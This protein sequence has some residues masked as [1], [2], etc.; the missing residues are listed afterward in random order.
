MGGTPCP[1]PRRTRGELPGATPGFRCRNLVSRAAKNFD[2]TPDYVAGTPNTPTSTPAGY[3]LWEY[4]LSPLHGRTLGT[5]FD[6]STAVTS[7]T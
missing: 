5:L 6:V 4:V 7:S 2:R 1:H 3:D